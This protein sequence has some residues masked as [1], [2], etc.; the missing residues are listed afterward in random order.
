MQETYLHR[1][2]GCK[3]NIDRTMDARAIDPVPISF[4]TQV[5]YLDTARSEIAGFAAVEKLWLSV[6]TE[7]AARVF[8]PCRCGGIL[9]TYRKNITF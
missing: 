3:Q 4:P 1:Q 8:F 5:P 9:L 6:L 2:Q 7:T